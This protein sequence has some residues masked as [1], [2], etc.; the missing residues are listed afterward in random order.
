MS[1]V[2]G[3][4]SLFLGRHL[5]N[6]FGK[7]KQFL[8][9]CRLVDSSIDRQTAH[10]RRLMATSSLL[11][12]SDAAQDREP[13]FSRFVEQLA[14]S[15]TDPQQ[16][17]TRLT[18]ECARSPTSAAPWL[19]DR[20]MQKRQGSGNL[21]WQAFW[22]RR[23]SAAPLV[24]AN[25]EDWHT[26]FLSGRAQDVEEQSHYRL[27]GF[28]G[29]WLEPRAPAAATLIFLPGLGETAQRWLLQA[30]QT[31]A[32]NLHKLRIIIPDPP[33]RPA[34]MCHNAHWRRTPRLVKGDVTNAWFETEGHIDRADELCK[35]WDESLRMVTGLIDDQIQSGIPESNIILGGY[36]QGGAMALLVAANTLYELGGLV[37]VNGYLPGLRRYPQMVKHRV[38]YPMLFCHGAGNDYVHKD[39]GWRAFRVM[40]TGS[41]V[42]NDSS[43]TDSLLAQWT[44]QSVPVD[45]PHTVP[46]EGEIA[47]EDVHFQ[48]LVHRSYIPPSP[49]YGDADFQGE[50]CPVRSKRSNRDVG[51]RCVLGN[52]LTSFV[53]FPNLNHG[54]SIEVESML[55]H[56]LDHLAAAGGWS[57][58]AQLENVDPNT[59][60]VC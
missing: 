40:Y 57:D 22:H 3:K 25:F 47:D 56:W 29:E 4:Q 27:S 37:V 38:T 9:A 31:V 59:F 24:S 7:M 43:A 18:T 19:M 44:V 15:R 2:C 30:E 33:Q 8:S 14:R 45:I 53:T 54:V 1:S 41:P 21:S 16:W 34:A 48:P 20:G 13:I 5:R 26:D 46:M 36:S 11:P 39:D 55:V 60:G 51:G 23:H 42:V 52:T 6:S 58:G 32:P 28:P 50:P 17:G 12:S 35:G 49:D 10:L